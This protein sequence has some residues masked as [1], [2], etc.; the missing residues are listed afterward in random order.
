M[1]EQDA[2]VTEDE[3]VRGD[4]ERGGGGGDAAMAGMRR[5]RGCGD[6]GDAAVVRAGFV[7]SRPAGAPRPQLLRAIDPVGAAIGRWDRR[8]RGLGILGNTTTPAQDASSVVLPMTA[9]GN[10][11]R[12]TSSA[13]IDVLPR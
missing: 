8:F 13:G 4:C 6:G 12:P 3:K 2:S 9:M 5:W 11:S 7:D 10:A 1:T